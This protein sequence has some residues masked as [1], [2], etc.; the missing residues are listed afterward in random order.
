MAGGPTENANLKKARII[1]KDGVRT[2]VRGVDL[3]KYTS[4][5]IDGRI[6]IRSEDVIMLPRR[7]RGFLGMGAT[8]WVAVIGGLSTMVL[9]AD[10]LNLWR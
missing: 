4:E 1:T 6:F 9:M 8:E 3:E 10:A 7:S 2:Q 5:A